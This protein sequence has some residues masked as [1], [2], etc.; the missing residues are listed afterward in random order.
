MTFIS[1]PFLEAVAV[2][3]SPKLE[4]VRAFLENSGHSPRAQYG[5]VQTIK[6]MPNLFQGVFLNKAMLHSPGPRNLKG[7]DVERSARNSGVRS[8]TQTRDA[9]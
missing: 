6:G 7:R 4:P 8:Y 9:S 2:A 1:H 3:G 5:L